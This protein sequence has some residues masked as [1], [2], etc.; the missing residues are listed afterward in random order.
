MKNTSKFLTLGLLSLAFTLSINNFAFAAGDFKIA[1]IDTQQIVAS[2]PQLNT[3]KNEQRQ[4]LNDLA[5]F[6]HN[7]N[8]DLA[9]ET[10]TTKKK[11]LEDNYNKELNSRKVAI[12]KDFT[13]RMSVIDRDINET[14]RAKSSGYDLVLAKGIVLN[15]GTDITNDVIQALK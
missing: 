10:D 4:K 7:A 15:G 14:I 5:A 12:D 6:I 9:K 8:A 13:S 2:S 11:A 3:L 1:V